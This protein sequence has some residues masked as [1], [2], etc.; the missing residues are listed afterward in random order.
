VQKVEPAAEPR[1]T[2]YA[3]SVQQKR[4]EAQTRYQQQQEQDAARSKEAATQKQQQQQAT[5]QQWQQDKATMPARD[6]IR[7]YEAQRWQLTP[8]V[9]ADLNAMYAQL[10]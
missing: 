2:A 4:A 5:R 8:D 6:L 10:R 3:Q 9:I 7:K 1:G